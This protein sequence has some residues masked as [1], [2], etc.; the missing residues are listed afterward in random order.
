M[1][2]Y[3]ATMTTNGRVTVPAELRKHLEVSS[4]DKLRFVVDYDG[5]VRMEKV[6]YPTI[7]SLRGIAG[8][9]KEPKSWE[10]IVEIAHDERAERFREKFLQG[11]EHS[12]E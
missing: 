6:K 10:E 12:P 11:D 9:L 1:P 8:S 5:A 3:L 4:G 2:E 7:A